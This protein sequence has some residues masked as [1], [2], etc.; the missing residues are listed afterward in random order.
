ML[1]LLAVGLVATSQAEDEKIPELKTT[2]GKTYHDVRIT[3]VTPS[4]ISIMHE[5]GA[6]RIPL[7]DLPEDLK[8]KFTAI[9]QDGLT[10]A[11]KMG[12]C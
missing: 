10:E 4:D 12:W 3:K 9:P 8:I 6:T 7:S 2:S 11:E 1:S 5:S